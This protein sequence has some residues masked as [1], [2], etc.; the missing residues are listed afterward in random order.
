MITIHDAIVALTN[1]QPATNH[2]L[3]TN[4]QPATPWWL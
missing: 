3:A 4:Q 1:Q 2:W